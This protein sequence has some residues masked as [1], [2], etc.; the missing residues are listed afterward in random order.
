MRTAQK[1]LAQALVKVLLKVLRKQRQIVKPLVLANR[2]GILLLK[3]KE[4]RLVQVPL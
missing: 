1:A 4:L 2:L 3:L